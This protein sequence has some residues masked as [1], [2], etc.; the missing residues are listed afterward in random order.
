LARVTV[1]DCLENVHNRFALV[2]LA[3]ERARQL[4]NGAKAL[5]RCDNKP[6]VTSL[7]E[8]AKSRVRFNESV[9]TTVGQYLAEVKT[10]NLRVDRGGRHGNYSAPV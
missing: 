5:V 7:R 3:A 9:E 6:A 10:R 2:I 1:E 8:I 4:A